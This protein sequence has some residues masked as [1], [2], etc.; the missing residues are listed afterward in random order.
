MLYRSSRLLYVDETTYLALRLKSMNDALN[1]ERDAVLTRLMRM[2]AIVGSVAYVPGVVAAVVEHLWAIVV[3]DTMAYAAIIVSALFPKTSPTFKLVLF[4]SASLLTGAVVLYFTGPL[5]AGY[6]WLIVAVV[7][8]ALFGRARA[9]VVAISLTM[10]IMIAWGLSLAFGRDGHGANPKTVII[11][12]GSMLVVCLGLALVIR[13]LLHSLSAVLLE[14]SRLVESLAVELGESKATRRRLENTMELKD[15][16]LR[17]LQHRVRNNLQVVQSLLSIDS[18]AEENR[19]VMSARRRVRALAASNDI[20][21]STPEEQAVDAYEL[22]RT[23]A[24]LALDGFDDA[25]CR[26]ELCEQNN[27]NIDQQN[28]SMIAVLLSDL[29]YALA[30]T[31]GIPAIRLE[32]RRPYL[33]MALYYAKDMEM[34]TD[35][36]EKTLALVSNGRIARSMVPDMELG[37]LDGDEGQGIFMRALIHYH[38]PRSVQAIDTSIPKKQGASS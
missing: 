16:L 25:Y 13:R 28:A 33:W 2:I 21:L 24:Q 17:E 18:N 32:S 29:V 31:S 26:V 14:K 34:D 22:V 20:F 36:M 7:M 10:T 6:I 23:V 8:S 19:A 35:A 11:I 27:M 4:V 1:H 37:M 9:V 38:T 3:I 5:G 15:E 12:S 30:E